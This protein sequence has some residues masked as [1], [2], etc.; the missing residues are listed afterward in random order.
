MSKLASKVT[1]LVAF[2]VENYVH[3]VVQRRANRQGI[4]VSEYLR[5]MV[6]YDAKRK[7]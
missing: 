1:K 4:K 6:T 5:N 7:R 2:R 3:S